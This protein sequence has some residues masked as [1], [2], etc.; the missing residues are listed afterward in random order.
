MKIICDKE[1]KDRW[2]ELLD[3]TLQHRH[4]N[5]S[6]N[7]EFMFF[8]EGDDKVF[9]NDEK[10]VVVSENR[11]FVQPGED[12]LKQIFEKEF[13]P[14]NSYDHPPKPITKPPRKS[15]ESVNRNKTTSNH[16]SQNPMRFDD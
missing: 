7:E 10:L 2:D 16:S 8:D 1:K 15:L 12:M 6:V 14:R 13:S 5:F 4:D 11:Q 3:K 9:M